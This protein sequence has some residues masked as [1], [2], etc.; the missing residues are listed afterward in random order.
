[1]LLVAMIAGGSE[2]PRARASPAIEVRSADPTAVLR[3][4]DP[5][6]PRAS[7]WS[8]TPSAWG[9]VAT[10]RETMP[11]WR[12]RVIGTP[13]LMVDDAASRLQGMDRLDEVV[14]VALGYNSLWRRDRVD[15]GYFS[16]RFDRAAER[17]VRVIRAGGGRK[18]VWITLRE[19]SRPDVPPGGREQHAT[20]AWYFPYVNERLHR[21]DRLHGD[22]VL[23]DWAEI[24][25]RPGITYD[26]FHLDP[27]GALLYSRL[28]RRS[29]LRTPFE[30]SRDG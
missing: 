25:S 16:T 11:R 9:S 2:E 4:L 17:L 23:A 30:P 15:Y 28:I 21:L 20:Y 18:V 14:V 26:A 19:A 3:P 13:A 24:S 10:L 7:R 5:S 27:D 8:P 22:V 1:M 29:V 12:I 6:W